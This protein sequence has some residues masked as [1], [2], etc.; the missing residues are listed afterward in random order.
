MKKI[1][2]SFLILMTVV[3]SYSC[4]EEPTDS[5]FREFELKDASGTVRKGGVYLPKKMKKGKQYPVIY[6]EDG[7]V[8]KDCRFKQLI[9]SLTD[10]GSINPVIVACS[11]ENKSTIPGFKLSY[12][13]AEFVESIARTDPTLAILFT[14]HINYFKDEFIPYIEKNYPVLK[15][16]QD[17][18]FFG[19]S[20]SADFGITFSM[21]FPSE[22][23]EYWCYSPVN[24]SIDEY[25]M[26][27]E[28]VSYRI[29]WGTKEEVAMFDYFPSL[30]KDIRKRG[31]KVQSWAFVGGHDR[32]M[33]R[34]T[35][36]EELMRRFP[37]RN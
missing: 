27:S 6:M 28:T 13:N 35:F 3:L 1:L 7:L 16:K 26:L 9:D 33:W 22:I 25:G 29:C 18:I 14:N 17:R 31:G 19:T 10:I 12:R 21:R 5:S 4:K 11:Y 32:G 24:S 2:V 15:S 23:A 36:G 30:V 37:Y 34:Y 20:N 8:F